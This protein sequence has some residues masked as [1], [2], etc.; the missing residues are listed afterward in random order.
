[1][2]PEKP[3]C[4][5]ACTSWQTAGIVLGH[6]LF[7]RTFMILSSWRLSLQHKA[8]V[9]TTSDLHVPDSL[10][11]VCWFGSRRLIRELGGGGEGMENTTPH[12]A[13]DYSEWDMSLE[14]DL[15]NHPLRL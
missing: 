7:Q 4:P 15:Y 11:T 5:G 12:T 14:L 6:S 1:M 2:A 3:T 8:P 10:T 13:M 9:G